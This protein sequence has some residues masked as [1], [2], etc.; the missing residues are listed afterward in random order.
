MWQFI[1]EYVWIMCEYVIVMK[2]FV[3]IMFENVGEDAVLLFQLKWDCDDW[4]K[5]PIPLTVVQEK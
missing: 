1:L 4:Q 5:Q 2:E 3:A